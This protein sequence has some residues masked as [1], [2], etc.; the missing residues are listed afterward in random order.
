MSDT[1][2]IGYVRVP[3]EW[4]V[5]RLKAAL[6]YEEEGMCEV[7]AHRVNDAL[8][9]PVTTGMLWWKKSRPRTFEE[10]WKRARQSPW[11]GHEAYYYDMD[12][13]L[14]STTQRMIQ[15]VLWASE[16]QESVLVSIDEYWKLFKKPYRKEHQTPRGDVA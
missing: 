7:F 3:S 6:D 8:N 13:W 5:P 2:P 10:A 4:A 16:E 1:L 14:K 11:F 15:K 9:V 12:W